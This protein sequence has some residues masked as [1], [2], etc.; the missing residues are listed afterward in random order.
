MIRFI[1]ALSIIITLALLAGNCTSGNKNEE[2]AKKYCSSCH[3][4]PEPSLLDKETWKNNV[5]PGMG[6]L[7]G[8]RRLGNNPF[9][10]IDAPF[11]HRP[12]AVPDEDWQRI[13]KYYLTES[14]ATNKLQQR[15]PVQKFTNLFLTRQPPATGTFPANTF[16]KIDPGNQ[17][18]YA[19]NRTDSSLYLYDAQLNLLQKQ[20]LHGVVVDMLFEN[21]LRQA[22]TRDGMFTII[23]IMDPNDYKTG[24][25]HS[26]QMNE[27]GQVFGQIKLF[28]TLPRPVQTVMA[29]LDADGKQDYLV[30]GFGN[31]Q[32]GFFWM[33]NRGDN[34]YERKLLSN[35]PGAIKAYVEDFNKDGLPDII[36]LF[37][38]AQEGIYLFL[39]K[40]NGTFEKQALLRFPPVYGSSYF[41]LC[42]VNGDGRKDIIYTCG[43]NADYSFKALKN[44]HG[45]YVFLNN[46]NLSFSQA[47]F[48]PIHGAYKAVARD[49]DKDGDI[50]IAAISFFPDYKNQ[51]QEAFVYLENK[52]ALQ[53]EPFTIK[54]FGQGHWITLDAAD[55]DKDG[56]DDIV[57]GSLY[58]PYQKNEKQEDLLRK[59]FF[60]LLLN[61]TIK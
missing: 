19:A 23:G 54:E 26:F 24:S 16:L 22:G 53:F 52:G 27:K 4:F 18:I 5:L 30:C 12:S 37:A 55:V 11:D 32:G 31:Q 10:E 61:Q 41:E 7:M 51:P 59:P 39:N 36:T 17:W 20:N 8:V 57:I 6:K 13:I 40:G 48:F 34:R 47:C 49:F 21:D 25:V 45:V 46:G 9:E 43:D 60:L 56:D 29:D 15:P 58:L 44:Y 42:D 3:L 14:P 38:Q 50:D 2:I 1:T 33:H 28:D 35:L